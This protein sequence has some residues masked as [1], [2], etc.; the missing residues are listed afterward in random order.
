MDIL[1]ILRIALRA[2]SRNKMRSSLTMLGI[3]IGVG[4]V[5]AMV[6]VGQGARQQ[7]QDQIAAMGSNILF[8]G[9]GSVNKGGQRTGFGGTKTLVQ[10][11]VDAILRE[12][13]TI[14]AIAPNDGTSG[15]MVYENQNWSTRVNGTTPAFFDVRLWPV[16]KGTIFSQD[17]VDQAA[18]VVVLG[19]TVATNLFGTTDPVGKTVRIRDLPFKVIG[20]LLSKGYSSGGMGG[21]QDDVAYMPITTMQKKLTGNTWYSF[22][23]CSAISKD[24]SFAAQDQISALL[25]DR[26]RIRPGQDDDF[27]VRNMAD[28]ADLQDQSSAVFTYLLASIASVSLLVGGIGIMNIMLVSV[29]ERTRE[30]GIR[31]AIGATEEDVQRQFL[32]EAMVLSMLGGAIGIMLGVG[33]SFLITNVLGWAVL[34]SPWAILAAALFS[35]AVG[36]FFGYYPARKAARLDPIEALRYE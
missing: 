27:F 18:N 29:T 36:V 5:I 1:S 14:K 31:M 19:T 25:R 34:I 24:A 30:I 26:H 33:S 23:M 7:V 6:G 10:G 22:V 32:I 8:V 17:D 2:L 16:Q 35:M 11:D 28:I 9:A 3:I 20:V 13:P 15:Q 4:A 12:V 21:D